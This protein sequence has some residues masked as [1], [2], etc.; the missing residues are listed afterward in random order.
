MF[1]KTFTTNGALDITKVFVA[2][3]AIFMALFI[4]YFSYNNLW[5]IGF[6]VLILLLYLAMSIVALPGMIYKI[7]QLFIHANW[8]HLMWILLFVSSLTLRIR[9]GSQLLQNPVDEAAF[10]RIV[11]IMLVSVMMLPRFIL[12]FNNNVKVLSTGALCFFSIYVIV[13]A[14]SSLYSS[15]PMLTLW[16]SFELFL[17]I[18]VVAMLLSQAQ[19]LSNIKCL[20]NINWLLLTIM[21]LMVWIGWALFPQLATTHSGGIIKTQLGGFMLASNGVGGIASIVA[22]ISFSRM[23]ST[24]NAGSGRVYFIVLLFALVTMVLAQSR[25]HFV[26]FPIAVVIVLF[27]QKKIKVI[28]FASCVCFVMMIV[29]LAKKDTISWYLVEFFR[30]GQSENVLFSLTGRIFMW[31]RALS[32]IAE[33]IF[34]GYGFGVGSRIT[35]MTAYGGDFTWIHNAWIEVLLNVGLIG[36]IPFMI[37]FVRIWEALISSLSLKVFILRREELNP[38]L[39]ELI[40]VMTVISIESLTGS[41]I[42]AWHTYLILVYISILA[43]A[44]LLRR[45]RSAIK[46]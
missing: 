9:T 5:Y 10:F 17:D 22:I 6:A 13:A 3:L 19:C 1:Y 25:T 36:L 35:F 28:T 42:G 43:F 41:G 12:S 46:V 37:A 7:K 33:R 11:L 45:E 21:M 24:K 23:L 20:M 27:L 39:I 32:L 40:G 8:L 29:F 2:G 44:N 4:L 18:S 30:R 14:V 31:K 16:K 26:A 34:L 38:F 15:Y